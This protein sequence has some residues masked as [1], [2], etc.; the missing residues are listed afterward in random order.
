MKTICPSPEI[1]LFLFSAVLLFRSTPSQAQTETH[2]CILY[3]A[4]ERETIRNRLAKE[5]YAG[6]RDQLILQADTV[7]KTGVSWD[8]TGVPKIIQAYYAKLL[9]GAYVFTDSSQ[10]NHKI[11][12]SEAAKALASVPNGS[13]KNFFSSS[14]TQSS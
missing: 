4:Q 5:P 9:A 2:P 3:L 11:Y 14:F 6:W 8:G 13:Y 1:L 7:L 10:V 12:G